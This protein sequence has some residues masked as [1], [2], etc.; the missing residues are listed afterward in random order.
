MTFI[1]TVSDF[2]QT[3]LVSLQSSAC[4]VCLRAFVFK[5]VADECKSLQY[6][7]HFGSQRQGNVLLLSSEGLLNILFE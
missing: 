1:N 2:L 7:S 3:L 4:C 6:M 5:V